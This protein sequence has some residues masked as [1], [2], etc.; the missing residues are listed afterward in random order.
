MTAAIHELMQQTGVRFGTSGAR[1]L[2]DQLTDFVAY[3]Y[4]QGFLQF[5]E[6]AGELKAK[7]TPVAVAGDFRPSTDRIMAAALRAAA[8]LGYTPVNCGKI[9]SPALAAWGLAPTMTLRTRLIATQALEPGD[10]VGYGST[11]L[12]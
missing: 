5:L 10:T 6:S 12:G 2:A 1:G 8:D 9:P 7:G 11:Y 3:A 4:T